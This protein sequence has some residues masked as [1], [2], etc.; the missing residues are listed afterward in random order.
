MRRLKYNKFDGLVLECN[1]VWLI[2]KYFPNF[3][4]FARKLSEELRKENMLFVTTIFPFTENISN[5]LSKQRYEYLNRYVDYFNIMTYD[6][7]T[8]LS[9]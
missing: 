6:Y 9:E 1:Q 3:T 5:Y 2:D 4:E 8:H 7:I